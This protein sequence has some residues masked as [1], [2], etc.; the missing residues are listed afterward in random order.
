MESAYFG[1]LHSTTWLGFGAQT[2]LHWQEIRHT[3][4]KPFASKFSRVALETRR[5]LSQTYDSRFACE[6]NLGVFFQS[7]AREKSAV[8]HYV[9]FHEVLVLYLCFER[10]QRELI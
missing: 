9:N 4:P 2:N 3:R 1:M 7:A 6:C 5:A 10:S 8:H